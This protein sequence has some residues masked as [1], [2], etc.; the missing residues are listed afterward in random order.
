MTAMSESFVDL[1]Y[2]G[3]ALGKRIKLTQ[4]R[5]QTGYLEMPTPMPV[6]TTIGIAT[7]DGVLLEA[8]VA[9]VR[10]QTG[11]SDPNAPGMVPGM[12]IR[13]NLGVEAQ[14]RWWR[15]RV[16]AARDKDAG[17]DKAPP[18]ADADGKVTLVSQRM[19]GETAIPE[20]MDDGRDTGV[21]DAVPGADLVADPPD[22]QVAD[23]PLEAAPPSER[24]G[25]DTIVVPMGEPMEEGPRTMAMDAVDLAALGLTS[26][27][28][29]P[30]VKPE[31]Y[32][33]AS[34]PVPEKPDGGKSKKKRTKRR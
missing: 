12:V 15:S 17:K 10:E 34:G 14:E 31:D 28:S 24:G 7:D 9:E 1:S 33:D 29:F 4:V 2:R 25:R 3:L 32:S 27:G 11:G 26:T 6:G 23:L 30:A 8:V 16:E 19:S 5:P 18:P 22:T 13:P 21:M 20:L